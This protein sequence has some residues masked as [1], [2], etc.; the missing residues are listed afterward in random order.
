MD[1]YIKKYVDKNGNL[2]LTAQYMYVNGVCEY[3]R[4]CI[5]KVIYVNNVIDSLILDVI[6]DDKGKRDEVYITYNLYRS[7][8]N[9]LEFRRQIK[10][11]Y[12]DCLPEEHNKVFTERIVMKFDQVNE[13]LYT[14]IEYQ[15]NDKNCDICEYNWEIRG[16]ID[17]F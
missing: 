17:Y 8:T 6:I 4:K 12:N 16:K 1:N 13:V 11:E 15:Y 5:F 2:E 10:L 9:K 14:D 3:Y 7:E